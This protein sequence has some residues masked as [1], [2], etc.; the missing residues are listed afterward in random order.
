MRYAPPFLVSAIV[1]ALLSH[2][3]YKSVTFIVPG[4]AEAFCIAAAKSLTIGQG[5]VSIFS[6]DSDLLVYRLS[7]QSLVVPLRDIEVHENSGRRSLSG[8]SF[9]SAK[10]AAQFGPEHDSL[11]EPAFFI[12]IDQNRSL[13]DGFKEAAK[14]RISKDKELLKQLTSFKQEYDVRNE[15]REWA[16]IQSNPSLCQNLCSADARISELIYQVTH[17]RYKPS[18][19]LSLDMFFPSL[20][21][22]GSRKTAWEAGQDIRVAAYSTLLAFTNRKDENVRLIEHNRSGS[23]AGIVATEILLHSRS[24]TLNKIGELRDEL[25]SRF[26]CCHQLTISL[27]NSSSRVNTWHLVILQFLID[28]LSAAQ[29]NLPDASDFLAVLAG[30]ETLSI[31]LIPETLSYKQREAHRAQWWKRFHLAAQYQAMYYSFRILQHLLRASLRPVT[32]AEAAVTLSFSSDVTEQDQ[33]TAERLS[34]LL[35]TLPNI[36]DFSTSP[37][38]SAESKEIKP[39]KGK[40][41]KCLNIVITGLQ[42]QQHQPKDFTEHVPRST[43]Q[44]SKKIV[45][46]ENQQGMALPLAVGT[47]RAGSKRSN[48]RMST[49]TN[50]TKQITANKNAYDALSKLREEE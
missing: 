19:G 41:E 47:N 28:D 33:Q 13:T 10:L 45:Q 6:N 16:N 18:A 48:C 5:T 7:E 4:E 49:K 15:S 29:K 30:P 3:E 14:L 12:K 8:T 43:S 39:T 38:N 9:S 27:L 37:V 22:D 1:E 24:E 26:H 31:E 20:L 21:E 35:E 25:E 2:D 44:A 42:G 11:V 46:A 40:W 32:A 36:L 17:K 50:N 34:S 23:P